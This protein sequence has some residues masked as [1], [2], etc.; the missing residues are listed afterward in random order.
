MCVNERER[1]REREM[2][3]CWRVAEEGKEE[4]EGRR[5]KGCC[6]CDTICLFFSGSFSVY[7]ARYSLCVHRCHGTSR[8]MTD[9]VCL[10]LGRVAWPEWESLSCVV[11]VY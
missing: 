5:S 9:C 4:E 6:L 1:L 7:L 3:V 8:G 2:C 10:L 11:Y